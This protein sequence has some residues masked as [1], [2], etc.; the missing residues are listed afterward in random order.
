MVSG[1]RGLRDLRPGKGPLGG[2]ETV[3]WRSEAEAILFIPCDMP[4]L[5]EELLRKLVREFMR[6]RRLPAVIANPTLE[7]LIAIVPR[8]F[9][10]KITNAVDME[11]LKVG[12]FWID[13]GFSPVSALD[14]S[15]LH[16][17]DYPWELP[18]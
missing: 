2:M 15:E 9:R 12:R 16:D 4:F 3:L 13:C 10:E 17:A 5:S 7:P 8:V 14:Y 1:R 18:A 11:H 6:N